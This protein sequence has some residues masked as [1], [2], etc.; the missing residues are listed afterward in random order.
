MMKLRFNLSQY[1]SGDQAKRNEVVSYLLDNYLTGFNFHHMK[2]QRAG[3]K[4][5][6]EE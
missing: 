5:E 3:V 1:D 2:P 6:E 4:N